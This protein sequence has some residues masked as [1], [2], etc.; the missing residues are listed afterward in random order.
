MLRKFVRINVPVAALS[1]LFLMSVCTC[2]VAQQGSSDE[3]NSVSSHSRFFVINSP[4]TESK[5][6]DSILTFDSLG[7]STLFFSAS[8]NLRGLDDIAC[9]SKKSPHF[10]VSHNVFDESISELLRFNASGK[11]V[12]TIPF[13]TPGSPIA[14]AFDKAGNF[15]VAQDAVIFKD[16]L[17]FATLPD[18]AMVGKLAADSRG[19]LY[20]TKPLSSQLFRVDSL[21]NVTLFADSTQGLNGPFGLA[22]DSMDNIFVANNPPSAPAF[23]LKFD[24]SGTPSPFATTIEEQPSIRSMTFDQHG[25][26]YATLLDFSS[27]LKFDTNG[28]SSIFADAS[29]GLDLPTAITV[30]HKETRESPDK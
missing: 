5:G 17:L 22:V 30:C 27:I 12:H 2:V 10:F 15:Y 7:N 18:A 23:I 13:G 29:K 3:P 9:S 24:Q 4:S 25:N 6:S 21:G 20:I 28:N 26:L 11:I 1:I 14:L 19:S 8:H 16:G